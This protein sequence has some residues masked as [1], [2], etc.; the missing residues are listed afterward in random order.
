MT[1]EQGSRF[2]IL[3]Y[4]AGDIQSQADSMGYNTL[5]DI[6]L[7]QVMENFSLDSDTQE[8][9][10]RAIR[11]AIHYVMEEMPRGGA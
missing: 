1:E 3:L 6:R 5:S 11:E 4:D 8:A 9:I 2:T 10:S 7:G